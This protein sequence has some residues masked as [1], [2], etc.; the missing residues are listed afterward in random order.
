MT[1]DPRLVMAVVIFNSRGSSKIQSV[2]MESKIQ[3]TVAS[4]VSLE[5]LD[6]ATPTERPSSHPHQTSFF[7][8]ETKICPDEG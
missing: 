8:H 7:G 3:F 5:S 6:R 1:S 2:V 4:H